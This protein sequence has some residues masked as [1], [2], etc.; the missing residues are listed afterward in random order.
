MFLGTYSPRL[1]E[2]GRLAFPAKYREDLEGGV[3]VAPGQEH[4]LYVFTREAFMER[5]AAL[6]K[7]S[8][9]SQEVRQRQRM[10]AGR[11]HDD[12]LDKQGR[13]TL[14]AH[15]RAHAGL[16][17]DVVVV[18]VLSHLEV[19]DA[20]RWAAYENEHQDS[21]VTLDDEGVVPEA[22]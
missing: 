1:D 20:E 8:L 2:K 11:A 6:A 7:S 14:P 4:C 18:G 19:W 3:V 12:V 5:T 21:Y 9:S 22:F 16:D 10:L 17:R 15:L 13:I